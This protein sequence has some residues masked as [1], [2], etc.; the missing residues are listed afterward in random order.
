MAVVF[1][2]VGMIV[3]MGVPLGHA[4]GPL[5]GKSE[6][7]VRPSVGMAVYTP[8]VPVGVGISARRDS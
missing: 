8:A 3:G 4:L 7:A 2:L 1:V 6:M 5:H